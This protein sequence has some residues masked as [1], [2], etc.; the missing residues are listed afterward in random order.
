V[1]LRSP[2]PLPPSVC[3][4]DHRWKLPKGGSECL[5]PNAVNTFPGESPIDIKAGTTIPAEIDGV[6]PNITVM[7]FDLAR[8]GLPISN[9]GHS[10]TMTVCN[11]NAVDCQAKANFGHWPK[12]LRGIT[13]SDDPT[14]DDYFLLQL[15]FH[16]G[17]DNTRGSEHQVCGNPSSAEMHMV[18]ANTKAYSANRAD[19][20]SGLRLAVIGTFIEGGAAED[21]A[22]YSG[23]LS[24]AA[25]GTPIPG[26]TLALGGVGSVVLSDL[27]PKDYD[28]KFFTYAG[29]LTT[30]PCS[31]I[32][33]WFNLENKVYWSDAQLEVLRDMQVNAV[34]S[35]LS[36]STY[37]AVLF[38][39]FAIM[40]G[41]ATL[42]FLTR[43]FPSVPYTVAMMLEGIFFGWIL[44]QRYEGNLITTTYDSLKQSTDMWVNI[45]GHV[46]LFAFL[47]AL[48]FG[49]AMTLNIHTFK[50]CFW[51]C[52]LLA[53]PGVLLGTILT[54]LAAYAILPYDWPFSFCLVFGSILSA[55][56]PV[57]VV[58]MLKELGASPKLTMQITGEALMNDGTA[59]VL[60]NIFWA[61][62]NKNQS[63]MYDDFGSIFTYFC[64]MALAGP[65]L[66]YAIGWGAFI[67]MG[68]ARRRHAHSDVIIQTSITLATAYLSF[69]VGESESKVSG[70]LTCCTAAGVLAQHAW[71][72][73]NS[74][75]SME[76]VWHAIEYFGNTVL[77]FL[78]GVITFKAISSPYDGGATAPVE[79]GG[80]DYGS[81]ILFFFV[82]T[83]IRAA[84]LLVFYPVLERLGGGTSQKDAGFMVWAGLR[85]AV[86]LSLAM[87]VLQTGGDQR[88]GK[89][90]V[91]V[92]AGLAFL[93][94]FVQG[95]TCGPL[96]NYWK[97]LGIPEVKAKMLEKVYDRVEKHC[98]EE[99]QQTC[100]GNNHDA[101]EAVQYLTRLESLSGTD[102]AEPIANKIASPRGDKGASHGGA[103]H[104]FE[105][106]VASDEFTL[107][108]LRTKLAEIRRSGEE[109][110]AATLAALRETH[111]RIVRAEYWEQI[112]SG[113][114]PRDA[115]AVLVLLDAIE[116]AIETPEKPICDFDFVTFTLDQSFSAKFGQ[117]MAKFLA[118][119]DKCLP[120]WFTL[121]NEVNYYLNFKHTETIY[122]ACVAYA[123]AH[124]NAQ[125]KLAMFFGDDPSP[126]TTEELTVIIESNLQ[127]SKANDLVLHMVGEDIIN[128]IKTKLVAERLLEIEFEY[129][130]KLMKE[131]VLSAK[132][133]EP[134][135]ES[136]Q[137]DENRLNGAQKEQAK[138]LALH[139]MFLDSLKEKGIDVEALKETGLLGSGGAGKGMMVCHE[140][141]HWQLVRDALRIKEDRAKMLGRQAS[142]AE[143]DVAF[144]KSKVLAVAAWAGK[145]KEEADAF[146][147]ALHKADGSG[148]GGSSTAGAKK[149]GTPPGRAAGRYS[150][151]V[152][153]PDPM[154]MPFGSGETD[155]FLEGKL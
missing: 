5:A 152:D 19:P 14:H 101:A 70:V 16:W 112:E 140:K 106:G 18:F 79:F 25:A 89:Q 113:Y 40:L 26:Q 131:G 93:T 44:Q 52:V 43:Y 132:E 58:T 17:R 83:A 32:V 11:T 115:E 114:L 116:S 81:V 60:F 62:Y 24:A 55:T 45:D 120:D 119:A 125:K 46:L 20:E 144:S 94:I 64:R 74:H 22:A 76:N 99:Y 41:T 98:V 124:E 142:K 30:P 126:D 139:Q 10:V 148:G 84:M 3:R 77:F 87:L 86:G 68:M 29:G 61:I 110:D 95:C 31:Q 36:H 51:Q 47:P 150:S 53:C 27:L 109:V 135:F 138:K 66:G 33:T 137:K 69:F 96:L 82:M 123:R 75:E 154:A 6:K 145:S 73:I 90:I 121:D 97:M 9:N 108:N 85:G 4:G 127:C 7:G 50:Q 12:T 35:Q 39:F 128:I 149:P 100:L 80:N 107:K 136:I 111:Y 13:E 122:Y 59:M 48:L 8:G 28:T 117:S 34:G 141:D 37:K 1:P 153:R 118:D 78:A 155:K 71:P 38:P 63:W 151:S 57:A 88:A 72:V 92:V 133:A 42:H 104:D 129:V 91:F 54:S 15:H 103:S 147:D 65:M 23:I 67:W 134:M 105:E 49:D 56:D 2:P 102:A 146:F 130:H 21:N 143:A